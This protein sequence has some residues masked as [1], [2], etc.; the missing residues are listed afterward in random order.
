M[1]NSNPAVDDSAS[2]VRGKAAFLT[3]CARCHGENA[4]GVGSE[5]ARLSRPPTNFRSPDFNKSAVLIAAHTSYGKGSD[6]PAFE[7]QIPYATIW[8]IANYLHSLQ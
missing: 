8:D 5:M 4:D 7:G 3:N 6:M 1:F 2:V